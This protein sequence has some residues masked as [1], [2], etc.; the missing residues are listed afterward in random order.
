MQGNLNQLHASQNQ[1]IARFLVLLNSYLYEELELTCETIL[2]L[3]PTTQ[4]KS[5][6]DCRHY[7]PSA[8]L[9]TTLFIRLGYQLAAGHYVLRILT[10]SQV[11]LR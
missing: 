2:F 11:L 9:P 6:A 3:E 10:E 5:E 4:T 8:G 1:S 7:S